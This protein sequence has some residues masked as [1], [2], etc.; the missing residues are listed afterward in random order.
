MTKP[1]AAQIRAFQKG[2]WDFYTTQ[3]RHELPWR[4]THDAYKILVSEVMLQQ[5]QVE[6]VIRYY[7]RFVAAY[8]TPAALAK[9]P[10]GDVLRLWQ[11]LGYNRRAKML[12]QAAK[13]VTADL[14]GKMPKTIE[15]LEELPGVG[16]YTARAVA[17]FAYDIHSAMVETNI[18]TA[19]FYHFFPRTKEV[20]DAEVLA[21]V[22]ATKPGKRSAREWYWALMDYG[23]AL[24]R[25]GEKL[26]TKSKHYVRQEP[27]E[28]SY[29][30]ARG[31]I[32]RALVGGPM[33]SADLVEVLGP[34]RRTQARS[35]IATLTKEGLIELEEGAFRLPR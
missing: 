14:K 21:I 27:F 20:S 25:A 18:R 15:G 6:R 12:H 8:P 35:S 13:V 28:G 2:V 31:I 32:L 24:K 5:T 9:A 7:E 23:S 34:K 26:N 1:R 10:L 22:E 33:A 16:H 29:R 30:Q 19:V 11:G 4:K 3:G 17:A